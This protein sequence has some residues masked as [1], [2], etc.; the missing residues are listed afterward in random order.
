MHSSRLD[1]QDRSLWD[2]DAIT[3]AT[4]ILD[5]TLTRGTPGPYAIQAA[6][7]ALHDEAPSTETTDWPQILALYSLL[8]YTT[9]NPVATLNRAVA[10]AM[11]HGPEAGLST[12]DALVAPGRS[13]WVE[14]G[15]HD[16]RLGEHDLQPAGVSP[17]CGVH[18]C[19]EEPLMR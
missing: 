3:E 4:N 11:V 6:I 8:D 18:E 19:P 2:R 16:R 7:A 17:A 13:G 12:V 5:E 10:E 1:E 15:S 14:P 9:Q